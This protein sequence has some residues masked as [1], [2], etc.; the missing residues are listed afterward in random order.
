MLAASKRKYQR[1][2]TRTVSLVCLLERVLFD[3]AVNVLQLRELHGLLHVDGMARGPGVDRQASLRLNN[4]VSGFELPT[5]VF[6]RH[7]PSLPG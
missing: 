4:T 6:G 3:H 5:H 7:S 2:K 1:L